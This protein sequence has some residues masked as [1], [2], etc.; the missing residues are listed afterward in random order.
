MPF[1]NSLL[2]VD[3]AVAIPLFV[4]LPILGLAIGGVA[5]WLILKHVSKKK[6]EKKLDETSKRVEEMLGEARAECKRLKKEAILESK[7]QDLKR[8]NEF[9][10]EMKEKRAEQ[11][12]MESRLS[13]QEDALER[14]EAELSKKSSPSTWQGVR[15]GSASRRAS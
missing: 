1:F 14:K 3:N 15:R 9:D 11:Q 2:L 8:R 5:V 12:R 10:Q 4:V 13:K 6:S 7:E